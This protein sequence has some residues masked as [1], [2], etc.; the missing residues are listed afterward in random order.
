MHYD[1]DRWQT[2]RFVVIQQDQQSAG[3]ERNRP[4]TKAFHL[5]GSWRASSAK[6]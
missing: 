4:A 2:Q 1:S 3:L 6:G 5:T